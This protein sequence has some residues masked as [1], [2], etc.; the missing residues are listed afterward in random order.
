MGA[1]VS[2]TITEEL[3]QDARAGSNRSLERLAGLLVPHVEM[4]VTVRLAPMPWQL[5]HARDIAQN[6]LLGVVQGL[7]RLR[8]PTAAGL[9]AFV[10]GVVDH[11]V[12]D[13]LRGRGSA[14][15]G[16]AHG[17]AHPV[18]D[19]S[20]HSA[21]FHSLLIDTPQ[22]G[23]TPLSHMAQVE[24][25]QLVM[26]AMARIEPAYREVI[27]L[28]FFDRLT[29]A[30]IAAHMQMARPAVSMLFLRAVRALRHDVTGHSHLEQRAHAD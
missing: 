20:Q 19:L 10:S 2:N 18:I 24:Q 9:R 8:T 27:I 5:E 11:K 1:G 21:S 12:A 22:S 3:V 15:N 26:E 17:V 16:T 28:S 25:F 29:T 23:S 4:M 30:Q 13:F 7:S 6:V 14:R